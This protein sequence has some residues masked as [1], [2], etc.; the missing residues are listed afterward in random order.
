MPPR[1]PMPLTEGLEKAALEVLE[2]GGLSWL[3]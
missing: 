1:T 2:T 3:D